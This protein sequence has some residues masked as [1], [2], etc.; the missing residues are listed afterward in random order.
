MNIEAKDVVATAVAVRSLATTTVL[1]VIAYRASKRF[2]A[3]EADR[4][5]REMWNLFNQLALSD[6][7]NLVSA[8]RLMS[9]E[10]KPGSSLEDT[11]RRWLG[12]VL[13]NALATTH[14]NVVRGHT[15]SKGFLQEL[16]EQQLRALMASEDLYLMTQQGYEHEFIELCAKIRGEV[17]K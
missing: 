15:L 1:A 7:R 11:R 6:D 13:L 17:T 8:D 16:L 2:A 4:V 5:V 9:H 14:M 10:S 3:L 12:Y